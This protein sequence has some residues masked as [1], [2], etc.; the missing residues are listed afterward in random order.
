MT[1]KLTTDEIKDLLYQFKGWVQEGEYLRQSYRFPG[2]SNA[3]DFVNR[4]AEAAEQMNHHP[5]IL[6]QFNKVSIT[7]TS[8]DVKGITRRDFKMAEAVDRLANLS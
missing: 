1:E 6:I 5:E 4:V 8:H 2:F 3:I 7:L